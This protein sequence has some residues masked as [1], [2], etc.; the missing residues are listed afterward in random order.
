MSNTPRGLGRGLD[1][2]FNDN[3]PK[4][5]ANPSTGGGPAPSHSLPLDKIIPN[6]GQPRHHFAKD[7]LDELTA[8][9]REQG[10]IQPLLVRPRRN[11]PGRYEIV[12]GERRWRAAALAGLKEV[13]VLIRELSDE[14]VMAAALIENLQREDLNPIE[15]A[16]ALQS[17]R[18][19]CGLT[20]EQL[21]AR[22][23]K[24]RPAIANA[25]RLLQLSMAAQDDL[26][27]GRINAGHARTLLSVDNVEA[28]EELRAVIVSRQM[29][30]RDAEAAAA[31]WKST[32]AFPWAGA[33]NAHSSSAHEHAEEASTA[34]EVQTTTEDTLADTAVEVEAL[35]VPAKP[36]NRMKS[37]LLKAVQSEIGKSLN[38]KVSVSGSEE[39][40]RITLTYTNAE[41]LG[42]ILSQW[43][44]ALPGGD[45][46]GQTQA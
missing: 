46:Q 27:F 26:Q 31:S 39:R 40:G 21:A 15:E 9:I 44:I 42:Q 43:G 13:P 37:P 1:A 22:V 45:A 10:I 20:Q 35:P 33:E 5:E 16:L 18:D 19:T 8:S 30:V 36:S 17:L 32:G 25:L 14:D 24:S 2:L 7:A 41:E 29:N 3:S 6:P 4:R 23:G 38:M 11:D 34:S 12:A 28:Q